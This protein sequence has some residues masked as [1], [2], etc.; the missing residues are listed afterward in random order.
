MEFYDYVIQGMSLR[1]AYKK[2]EQNKKKK[3]ED[4]DEKKKEERREF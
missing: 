1:F 2:Y 3:K 4:K